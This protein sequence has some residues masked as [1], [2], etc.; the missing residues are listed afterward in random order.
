MT[1]DYTT[2]RDMEIY[3]IKEALNRAL[4]KSLAAKMLGIT[5]RTLYNKMVTYDLK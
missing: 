4:N 2:I 1:H 5:T 3:F